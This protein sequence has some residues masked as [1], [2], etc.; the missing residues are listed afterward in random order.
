M[1]LLGALSNQELQARL[2]RL[3][4]KLD[5]VAAGKAKPRRSG[6]ADRVLRAGVVPQLIT[7]VFQGADGP[8]LVREVHEHVEALLGK[9]VPRSSI[10]NWL[11]KNTGGKNA[12][13][14]R[15]RRGRYRLRQQS[16]A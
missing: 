4:D 11:A 9:P 3:S 16:G 15:L 7:Q 13:F 12:T 1:E 5:R 10:K 2:Q 6:R 8:L 14:V